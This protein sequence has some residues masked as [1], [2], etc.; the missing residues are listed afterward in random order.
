MIDAVRE[1][2]SSADP[3][4]TGATL[5]RNW[6]RLILESRTRELEQ[7]CLAHPEPHDPHVL[8][9]RACCRDLLGDSHGAAFLRGQGLRVAAD[10][11]VVC[12]T[13]LLLTA[14]NAGKAAAADRARDA[15]TDCG[16]EDDYPSALFLLGWT[17]VRLRRDLGAAIGLLRSAADEARL[18]GRA[19]T[20]RL[21]QSNLAFAL[22]HAGLF[23]EAEQTLDAL[24][25]SPS[26]SDWDLFE[27]GLPHANRG[28]IAYWRGEYDEAVSWLDAVVAEGAPGHN[29]EALARLYLVMTLVA[30]RREDRYFAAA[31]LLQGV[32]RTDKHGIPWDTLRRVISAQLAHAE[33]QDAR[34]R[35]IA[36]PALARPGAAVA[37]AVLAE[38]Y[39]V[40]EEPALAT[41]ALRLATAGA[42]PRYA[43]VSTLVTSAALRSGAGHGPDAHVH[44]DRALEAA[45]PERILAPFL[46]PD[47]LIGDLLRA[48]AHRG[49]PHDAFLGVILERRGQLARHLSGVLTPRESEVLACLRTTMTAEEISGHLGVAYPT[50]KTHIRSIYRKLGVTSR[51]AAIHVAD[52]R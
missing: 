8:L 28:T 50:V 34:A 11:F 18:H 49:S 46:S 7:L 40:L 39:R 36:A 42:L 6:L 12:F 22:T 41:Q 32:S 43:R 51:R 37:H 4:S 33:G 44:I 19:E 31:E 21:A 15:L 5:R 1:D 52:V 20:F 13:D 2:P 29:F 17:E 25:V 30:L 35:S 47:P 26:A 48:H 10:D 9:I 23:T 3:D 27:G 45:A 16:P 24:P 38:L 14:D